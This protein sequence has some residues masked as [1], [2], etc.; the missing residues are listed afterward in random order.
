M[1]F[2]KSPFFAIFPQQVKYGTF[3]PKLD[4]NRK[5]SGLM[6]AKEAKND[7]FKDYFVALSS[8]FCYSNPFLQLFS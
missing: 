3:W 4:R 5:F 1:Y 6:A 7:D 2:F 8:N